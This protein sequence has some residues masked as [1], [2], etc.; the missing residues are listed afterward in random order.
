MQL[1][2]TYENVS[3]SCDRALTEQADIAPFFWSTGRHVS[4]V[5]W[6]VV[7]ALSTT[8]RP[9]RN[10]GRRSHPRGFTLLELMVVVVI[11]TI[12]SAMA[13][14]MITAQMRDRRTQ[15][16][17]QRVTDL[18]RGARMRAMGRGSAV[19]VRFS[20]GT[21]GRFDLFEAQRGTTDAPVGASDASCASLPNP[22]CLDTNWNDPASGEFRK[23][24]EF[25]L[26]SRGEYDRLTVSMSDEG[27]LAIANLDICFTPMGRAFYRTVTT[28]PLQPLAKSHTVE[29]FRGTAATKLGRERK[30]L[31]LPNG[32]ARLRL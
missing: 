3:A 12:L 28:A 23:V 26:A 13:I 21:R 30:V 31:V 18:L 29:V 32:V 27:G 11:I 24:T 8:S 14:P 15:D 25:D 6:G 4:C 7:F 16:A 20:P 5:V 22:S 2:Q 1:L 17:A 10:R 19:L 9:E